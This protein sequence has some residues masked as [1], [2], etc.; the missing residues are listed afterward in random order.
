MIRQN[1]NYYIRIG[2]NNKTNQ[3]QIKEEGMSPGKVQETDT[4]GR[5]RKK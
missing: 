3:K 1:K 4:D 5:G 2:Q